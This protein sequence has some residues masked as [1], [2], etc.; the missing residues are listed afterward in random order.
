VVPDHLYAQLKE[1]GDERVL[2]SPAVALFRGHLPAGAGVVSGQEIGTS[3]SWSG[4]LSPCS[5]I[6]RR[7]RIRPAVEHRWWAECHR[8]RIDLRPRRVSAG[9]RA[10]LLGRRLRSR[11]IACTSPPPDESTAGGRIRRSP[12]CGHGDHDPLQDDERSRSPARK[13]PRRLRAGGREKRRH[14]GREKVRRSSPA[15]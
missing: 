4:S 14:R 2:F 6:G 15:S 7:L 11:Q 13:P 10:R 5:S 1:A 9:L 8:D 3:S 12:S